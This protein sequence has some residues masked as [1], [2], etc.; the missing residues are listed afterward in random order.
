ML[1][2]IRK[3]RIYLDYNNIDVL[4]GFYCS[5]R[6]CTELGEKLLAKILYTNVDFFFSLDDAEN[7][8]GNIPLH[9][10]ELIKENLLLK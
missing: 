4:F 5:D 6:L 3:S 7:I 10:I 9:S 8:D 1:A 2:A